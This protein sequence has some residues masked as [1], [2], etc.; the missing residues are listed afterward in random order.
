MT[1]GAGSG[2][3]E[4]RELLLR[5]A[6]IFK[7]ESGDARA[8]IDRCRSLIQGATSEMTQIFDALETLAQEQRNSTM[9]ALDLIQNARFPT[10][11]GEEQQDFSS[12]VTE[13]NETLQGLTNIIVSFA[14]ENMRVT[15]SVEDLVTELEHVFEN[16]KRVDIIADDTSMLA[17]NAALEAARAGELGR[18]FGVVS[19]E[20]R[21]L[22]HSVKALNE[23]ISTH[24][25]KAG[26]VVNDVQDA[27]NGLAMNDLGLDRAVGFSVRVGHA[28]TYIEELN[29]MTAR[30]A[31]SMGPIFERVE[32][33]VSNAMRA[34]Q[35]EDI[36]TQVMEVA[37]TR[38]EKL[39]A[40]FAEIVETSQGEDAV[41]VLT[42]VVEAL[43]ESGDHQLHMPAD[44]NSVDAGDAFLF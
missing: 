30:L 6:D 16:V 10:A 21:A 26:E 33:H 43:E 37:V 35:F 5:L 41:G 44:Q 12:F 11:E 18:G 38:F 29:S 40:S 23:V 27:V 13:A 4:A 15:Y 2:S 8:D 3:D 28:L 25:E 9:E 32:E 1:M 20:V 31:A 42:H 36:A 39:T 19:S 24:V 34:L 22:S 17:I 14:R 7:R